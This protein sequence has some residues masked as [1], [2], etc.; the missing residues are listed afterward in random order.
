MHSE[1]NAEMKVIH[2][3]NTNSYSGAE[4]VVITIINSIKHDFEFYYASFDGTIREKLEYED[5]KFYPMEKISI[6]KIRKL[7]KELKPDIIHAH[8]FTTSLVC[9]FSG[10]NVPI[11]S[12]IHNN[13]PWLKKAGVYSIAYFLSSFRYKKILV[14]SDSVLNEYVF[15]NFIKRKS[16]VVGN[17]IDN[18]VVIQKS[19]LKSCSKLYD[20][21]FLGRLSEQKNPFKFIEIIERLVGNNN[22]I[23][24][25]MIGSGEMMELCAKQIKNKKLSSNIDLLGFIDNPYPILSNSKLLIMPSKWEGFGLAAVEALALGIPVIATPVGGLPGIV[26]DSCGKVCESEEDMIEETEKLLKDDIYHRSKSN[27][28]IAKAELINNID[29]YSGKMKEMYNELIKLK[30]FEVQR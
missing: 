13:P 27:G 24:A 17:P 21:I 4:N 26:D 12:H 29:N 28:A 16:K 8:D 14:V 7:V 6:Y 25:A 30:D 5:I 15:S 1:N 20:I 2:I 22:Q 9:A 3:L 10:I 19:K 18:T 11:I 23:K